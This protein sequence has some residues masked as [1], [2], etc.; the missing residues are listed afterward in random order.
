MKRG[1]S[2]HSGNSGSVVSPSPSTTPGIISEQGFCAEVPPVLQHHILQVALELPASKFQWLKGQVG[3]AEPSVR[4]C[5]SGARRLKTLSY[6]FL[7]DTPPYFM[8]QSGRLDMAAPLSINEGPPQL[9]PN[10]HQR[11]MSG[12]V[13]DISKIS[14]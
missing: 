7:L 13:P 2:P 1:A 8:P 11:T 6:Q 4:N 12:C 10:Y 9:F 14:G 5:R 3:A